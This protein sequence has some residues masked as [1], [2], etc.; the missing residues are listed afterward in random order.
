[1]MK[2]IWL[3]RF[4][5]IWLNLKCFIIF[6]KLGRNSS[7]T[8]HTFMVLELAKRINEPSAVWEPFLFLCLFNKI[9]LS[10]N[11]QRALQKMPK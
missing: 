7:D 9:I 6:L 2:W 3:N 5:N 8:S 10:S 4:L 1:M 11:I